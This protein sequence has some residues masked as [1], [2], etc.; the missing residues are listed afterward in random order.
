MEELTINMNNLLGELRNIQCMSQNLACA[1]SFECI[2]CKLINTGSISIELD[3]VDS[4]STG[5]S[6]EISSFSSIPDEYSTIITSLR[7]DQSLYLRGPNPS[8]F[9]FLMTPSLFLNDSGDWEKELKGYHVTKTQDPAKG[10]QIV[11]PE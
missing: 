8:N 9:Y 2:N 5:I 3:E 4:Y 10:S 1:V 7:S 6:V 11:F